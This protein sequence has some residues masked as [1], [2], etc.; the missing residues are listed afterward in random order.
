MATVRLAAACAVLV[1]AF[2][3]AHADRSTRAVNGVETDISSAPWLV[4][5]EYRMGL[6]GS[7]SD[8]MTCAGSILNAN[9]ILTAG[10][11]FGKWWI[12]NPQQMLRV[13]A[14]ATNK[15]EG[16]QVVA[17]ESVVIH[18]L[19]KDGD[20]RATHDVA[21]INLA[22]PLKLGDNAQAIGLVAEDEMPVDMETLHA[23]GWG[24]LAQGSDDFAPTLTTVKVSK[25]PDRLCRSVMSRI[26]NIDSYICLQPRTGLPCDGDSGS[27]AWLPAQYGDPAK[28]VGVLHGGTVC[29]MQGVA[30]YTSV[31]DPEVQSF[32]KQHVK[33]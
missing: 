6:E 9:Q 12:E 29:S 20:K 10:H 7:W 30:I 25:V 17:A 14:G 11:C 4:Q 31:N 22:E 18:P 23:G 21:I 3:T 33:A 19:Y 16:G 24:V 5:I 15:Q 26:M 28:L 2:W 13:R 8:M 27:P 1:A 32:L